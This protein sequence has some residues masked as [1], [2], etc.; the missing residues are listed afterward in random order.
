MPR[1]ARL[2]LT[3]TAHH[4]VQRGHNRNVVFV[5]PSD[6]Q[7]Y[8]DTLREWKG[9]SGVK[10][11]GYCLMVNHVHLILNPGENAD[12]IG[13]LM[14]RL[15]GRQTRYVNR[16]ENRSGS[17]WEGRYKSSPIE[18]DGYLLACSRYVDLNPVRAKMVI[19]PKDYLWSSYCQ[20]V[21]LEESWI[22]IDPSYSS[23]SNDINGC[24]RRYAEFVA[25]GV[26]DNEADFIRKAL[27]RGQ[28]T[29]NSRFIDEVESRS[30]V[31]IE[32]RGQGRPRTR[33]ASENQT[34]SLF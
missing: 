4:I 31:R 18:T 30:G 29:G 3:N 14:K 7:Y 34:I 26:P 16:L 22:D 23:L 19:H 17:L 27:V 6:F 13:E 8:L 1:Q 28:L 21:G 32:S 9:K 33:E 20:K 11:Y 24:R 5:A 2:I 10:V 15:A 12:S 25:E